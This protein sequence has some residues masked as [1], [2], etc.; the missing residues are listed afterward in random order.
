M[1]QWPWG[2]VCLHKYGTCYLKNLKQ[3]NKIIYTN[4]TENLFVKKKRYKIIKISIAE[5]TEN[6][7][8]VTRQN[9][10]FARTP[11]NEIKTKNGS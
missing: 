3:Q 11:Y 5:S 4:V 1:D 7:H 9:L 10:H 8:H 2:Y 6:V